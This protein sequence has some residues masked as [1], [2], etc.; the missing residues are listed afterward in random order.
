M[1][2]H[3]S[4]QEWDE[5]RRQADAD[6]LRLAHDEADLAEVRAI[7]ADLEHLRAE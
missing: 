6:V 5:L 2:E 7:Q 4:E 3:M 1:T